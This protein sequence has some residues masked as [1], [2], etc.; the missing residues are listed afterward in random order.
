[1]GKTLGA[2][3]LVFLLAGQT[4]AAE[5]PSIFGEAGEPTDTWLGRAAPMGF[6]QGLLGLAEGPPPAP[7][8]DGEG[9]GSSGIRPGRAL[10]MSAIVP[11][12]GELLAGARVRAA[13]F[14]GLELLGWGLYLNWQGKGD[15]IEDEFRET[16]DG[17]WDPLDYLT[18]RESTISSHSSITH[19][20]PC[21]TQIV[22][23]IGLGSCP[24]TE[25]QQYYELLGKYDQF[26]AGWDDVRDGDDNPVQPTQID[27][28]ENYTSTLRLSYEDRRDDSNRYLKRASNLGGLILVNHVL[29][30]VDAARVA[31]G[32][33]RGASEA[34]LAQ[35]TRF[36]V[37]LRPWSRGQVPM[38][39]AA[40]PF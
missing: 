39:V 12:S 40:K 8:V 29:S 34:E 6:H 4:A 15:D 18:W 32:R 20:L 22:D 27:S 9:S 2:V 17:H 37:T 11:G 1:M 21:S 28:V 3:A 10:L 38:L 14:F 5:L 33:A 19:A 25:E 30:A 23:G 7:A 16:A 13:V 35:R 24:D 31:R 36:L 26:V